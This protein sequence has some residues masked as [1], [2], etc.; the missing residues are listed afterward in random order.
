MDRLTTMTLSRFGSVC[1]YLGRK[2]PG[3]LRSLSGVASRKYPS[4]SKLTLKAVECPV[5]GPVISLR[6]NQMAA[7]YAS[8]AGPTSGATLTD[9]EV[10]AIHHKKGISLQDATEGDMDKCPHASAARHAA[11]VA[12]QLSAA[13]RAAA[14]KKDVPAAATAGKCPFHAQTATQAAAV[15]TPEAEPK[16]TG[17]FNYEQFYMGE[18]DKKHNDA[19]Y[20]Y[21]NNINRLAAKFPVAHTG[22]LKDEVE[23]WCAND[24]L[25]MGNNPVVIET[26]QCVILLRPL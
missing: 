22:D 19:S 6:S 8:V 4:V 16:A 13:K 11:Q 20:R 12:E 24:Y 18:L 17:G 15:P 25:G 10:Q 5:M 21:F 1:P 26:M 3:T 9:P 23:V 2:T 7:G 14:D